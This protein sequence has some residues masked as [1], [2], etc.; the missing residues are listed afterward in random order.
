MSPRTPEQN[1]EIRQQRNKQI[2]EAAREVYLEKGVLG[3]EIGEV[4]KRAGIARALVYYYYKD[5]NDLFQTLFEDSLGTAVRFVSAWLKTEEPALVRL[6][7]Y[8]SHYLH[9]AVHNP[10]M[11]HFFRNLHQDIPLVFGD[12]AGEIT[13]VFVRNIHQPLI[14]TFQEG[15]DE[16]VLRKSDSYLTAHMFWGSVSGAMFAITEKKMKP[17]MPET[18]QHIHAAMEVLFKGI[19]Q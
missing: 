19:C 1:E 10:K 9:N 18:E 4:A 17:N 12:K 5:K 15:M 11:V 7:T 8:A 6:Q 16:G 2:L 13:K 14:D 3:T